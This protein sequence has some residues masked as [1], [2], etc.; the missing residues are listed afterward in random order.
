MKSHPPLT[1][2]LTVVIAC[3][4]ARSGYHAPAIAMLVGFDCYL[5]VSE[6]TGLRRCD[7]VMSHDARMGRAHTGMAVCLPQSKTGLNQSVSV[8][9]PDALHALDEITT[10]Q[11]RYHRSRIRLLTRVVGSSHAQRLRRSRCR[12]HT[13]CAALPPARW[14]YRRFPSPEVGRARSLSWS[15][16][17]AR[18][19]PHV[20]SAGASTTRRSGCTARVECTRYRAQ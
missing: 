5:R 7:V 19:T 11:R 16:E 8:Q 15:M 4:L 14:C 18:V 6:I 9:I 10:S 2:E 3:T 13:V 1:W 20:H 12:S 17:I